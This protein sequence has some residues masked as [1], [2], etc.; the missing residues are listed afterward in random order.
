[1]LQT[2]EAQ[3]LRSLPINPSR[4]N[5]VTPP[6]PALQ[7]DLEQVPPSFASNQLAQ[8]GELCDALHR[9]IC[10]IED[11]YSSAIQRV[12]MGDAAPLATEKSPAAELLTDTL[13]RHNLALDRAC[14]RL[15]QL[16]ERCLL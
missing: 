12:P 11:R 10:E 2:K 13:A 16:R 9:L 15:V 7:S 1:M 6:P 4:H 3:R 14:T 8:Q 5:A